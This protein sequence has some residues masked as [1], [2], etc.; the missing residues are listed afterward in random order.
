VKEQ[1]DADVDKMEKER[2]QY[3]ENLELMIAE[4]NRATE[5]KEKAIGAK[6]ELR[7]QV[8]GLQKTIH[9]RNGIPGGDEESGLHLAAVVDGSSVPATPGPNDG[10]QKRRSDRKGSPRST[11][12]SPSRA[13]RSPSPGTKREEI[14]G[15]ALLSE[16]DSI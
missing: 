6:E 10:N 4:K 15:L 13:A 11:A 7:L 5:E 12:K 3:T 9:S 14:K 2:M 8:D 16:F 1:H